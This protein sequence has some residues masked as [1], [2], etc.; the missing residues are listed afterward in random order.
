M[1]TNTL[2]YCNVVLITMVKS[3]IVQASEFLG[4]GGNNIMVLFFTKKCFKIF[5]A[6]NEMFKQR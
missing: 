3:I 5:L 2:A 1:R 6:M 4:M